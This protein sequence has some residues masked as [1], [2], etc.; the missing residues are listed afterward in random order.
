MN[1]FIYAAILPDFRN[2][3]R[4]IFICN[5]LEKR[6]NKPPKSNTSKERQLVTYRGK[7]DITEGLEVVHIDSRWRDDRDVIK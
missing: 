1:P 3:V 2:L 6:C 5:R 4:D 7:E